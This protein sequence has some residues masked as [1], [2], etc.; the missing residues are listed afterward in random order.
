MSN[1]KAQ[2]TPEFS[3]RAGKVLESPYFSSD[4]AGDK[5]DERLEEKDR[6]R[7]A[8]YGGIYS[9]DDLDEEC[10]AIWDRAEAA[11]VQADKEWDE[12]VKTDKDGY[13]RFHE[14]LR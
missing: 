10:K 11:A 12:F 2:M 7:D 5:F 1:S 4:Q 8:I 6:L 9:Y 13:G 14:D 3:R